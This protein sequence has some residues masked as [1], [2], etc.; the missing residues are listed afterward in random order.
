MGKIQPRRLIRPHQTQIKKIDATS[1]CPLPFVV[2]NLLRVRTQKSSWRLGWQCSTTKIYYYRLL[3]SASHLK[4]LP[5][6]WALSLKKMTKW[7]DL[8][9]GHF[10]PFIL[11]ILVVT[12]LFRSADDKVRRKKVQSIAVEIQNALRNHTNYRTPYSDSP[13]EAINQVFDTHQ[14]TV[15][16]SLLV[17]VVL[18]QLESVGWSKWCRTLPWSNGRWTSNCWKRARSQRTNGTKIRPSSGR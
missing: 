9:V 7:S 3:R 16:W 1:P 17:F 2:W 15:V 13:K 5:I 8:Y 10:H 6:F 4:N 11:I 18:S 12:R 14:R